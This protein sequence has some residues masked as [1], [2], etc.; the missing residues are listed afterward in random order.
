MKNLNLI[1]ALILGNIFFT[2][3]EKATTEPKSSIHGVVNSSAHNAA[4]SKKGIEVAIAGTY[5]GLSFTATM[6]VDAFIE[7]GG[8]LMAQASLEKVSGEVSAA[9]VQALQQ[10]AYTFAGVQTL[11]HTPSEFSFRVFGTVYA[12][13]L[14]SSVSLGSSS[15]TVLIDHDTRKYNKIEDIILHISTL[16]E[17]PT[18]AL[19]P[20]NFS[21][22]VSDYNQASSI[23]GRP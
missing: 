20:G 12:A 16:Y 3:C 11:T 13:L 18:G 23:I 1:F 4:A 8:Q 14:P 2:S 17:S 6:H 19:A 22:L 10:A 5:K 7:V 9:D 21:M 15:Y